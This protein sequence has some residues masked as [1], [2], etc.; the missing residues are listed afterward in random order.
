MSMPHTLPP[1]PHQ[2]PRPQGEDREAGIRR[3]V[4]VLMPDDDA[5]TG[6]R[7]P[8]VHVDLA[9]T[10]D[11]VLWRKTTGPMLPAGYS[12]SNAS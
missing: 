1:P 8:E 3:R 2:Q 4:D 10:G 11:G 5:Q 6:R 12:T 7:R 9:A